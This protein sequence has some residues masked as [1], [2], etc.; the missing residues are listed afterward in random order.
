MSLASCSLV[1]GSR[2]NQSIASMH[3]NLPIINA[4]KRSTPWM[5]S[6]Q[7]EWGTGVNETCFL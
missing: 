7:E 3:V 5:K 4:I 1:E 6:V 2:M